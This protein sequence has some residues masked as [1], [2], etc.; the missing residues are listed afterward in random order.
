MPTHTPRTLTPPRI[1]LAVGAHPDDIEFMMAGTL[2]LLHRAGWETHYLNVASGSCGSSTILPA[3]L[4]AIRRREARAAAKILGAACHNS[5]VDDLEI[6]YQP[7]TLRRLAALVREIRP[8]IFLVPSPQDYMEDHTNT[9]RLA[10]TAAF[11]RGMRNFRT[12]PPRP[13]SP[14]DLTVYHA[15]PHGL[16]DPL[17]QRIAPGAFVDTTSV[18]DLKVSAL[19]QHHSQQEWLSASQGMNA[20]LKTMQTFARQLGRMSRRFKFAEGWRRH[21]HYGFCSEPADPLRDALGPRYLANRRYETH[22]EQPQ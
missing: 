18:H 16:R 19:E 13:P 21:L 9:C 5:L 20:Y 2:T 15:M 7:S 11:V 4:R 1:A 14:G 6:Y 12:H 3:A 22:L 10:V 8:N 17:R